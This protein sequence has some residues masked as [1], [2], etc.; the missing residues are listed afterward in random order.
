[1]GRCAIE[2]LDAYQWV[3]NARHV[4][5]KK[6]CLTDGESTTTSVMVDFSYM[7][8]IFDACNNQV[9]SWSIPEDAQSIDPNVL[10][11][12]YLGDQKCILNCRAEIFDADSSLEATYS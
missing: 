6:P 5:L 9:L 8:L 3:Y 1:M 4:G 12:Q 11:T 10:N 7:S 2:D